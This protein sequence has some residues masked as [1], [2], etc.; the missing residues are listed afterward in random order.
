[1]CK[2]LN[3]VL[4]IRGHYRPSALVTNH[5]PT[6][7]KDTRRIMNEAQQVGCFPHSASGRLKYLLTDYVGL[8]KK[9]S[10]LLW[11][12]ELQMVLYI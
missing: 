8:D 6:N 10:S 3:K 7:G 2:V 11:M 5:V 12:P 9:T 1:M 4:E